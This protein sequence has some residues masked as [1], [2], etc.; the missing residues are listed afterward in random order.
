MS[1]NIFTRA[2]KKEKLRKAA[3][4]KYVKQKKIQPYQQ[5]TARELAIKKELEKREKK[6]K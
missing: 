2:A 6:G 3:Q 5:P 4:K 1:D